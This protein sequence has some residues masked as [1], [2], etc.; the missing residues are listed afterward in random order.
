[1]L[2]MIKEF[3]DK[4]SG[5]ELMLASAKNIKFLAV[6][7]PE[8]ERTLQV[9]L[10]TTKNDN[11]DLDTTAAIFLEETYFFKFRGIFKE[12]DLHQ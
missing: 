5:K 8:K 11:G 2:Q 4:L 7:D 10:T 9:E 12:R 3:T 6:V 1:M